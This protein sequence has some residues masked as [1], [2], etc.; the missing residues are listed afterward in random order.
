VVNNLTR[1]ERF[2]FSSL[3]LC[4]RFLTSDFKKFIK[5]RCSFTALFESALKIARMP[6]FDAASCVVGL[7]VYNEFNW[8]G[9]VKVLVREC[10]SGDG[11]RAN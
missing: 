2:T 8:R 6:D 1:F 4:R 3:R 11:A 5:I 7:D 10:W 9:Y